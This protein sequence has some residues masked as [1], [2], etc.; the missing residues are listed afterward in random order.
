MGSL[1]DGASGDFASKCNASDNYLMAPSSTEASS[2]NF[3][4]SQCSI[5][6]FKDVLLKNANRWL[7]RFENTKNIIWTT[8]DALTMRM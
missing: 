1:H 2:S 8:S 7:F 6:K 4:F 3:V 5:N